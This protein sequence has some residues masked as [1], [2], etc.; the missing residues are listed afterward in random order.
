MLSSMDGLALRQVRT[1]RLRAVLTSFGIV[2]GVGMVFGVLLLSGTIR[3][4]FDDI[5]DS[6]WGTKDLIVMPQGGTLPDT[7]LR[8]IESA[9]GV[10]AVSAWIGGTAVRFDE[11]GKAITGATKAKYKLT[12]K[13]RRKRIT[14]E[15]TGTKL[16]Y[17]AVA[18]TSA[19]TKRVR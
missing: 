8:V 6:A 9:P 11:H 1:R 5:V 15:V 17:R 7:T 10:R 12:R 4:T 16:G 13:D 3:N 14:V 18:A 2:L 19:K